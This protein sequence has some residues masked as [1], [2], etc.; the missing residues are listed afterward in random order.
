MPLSLYFAYYPEPKFEEESLRYNHKEVV[1]GLKAS[2]VL[3]FQI[4]EDLEEFAALKREDMICVRRLQGK[5]AARGR[6]FK[7]NYFQMLPSGAP[8]EHKRA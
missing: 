4:T 3:S 2:A 7:N 8:E 5:I 6:E 1:G